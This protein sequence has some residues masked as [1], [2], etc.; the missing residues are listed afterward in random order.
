[1]VDR[2][3]T[4]VAAV[5]WLVASSSNVALLVV[6]FFWMYCVQVQ[7]CCWLIIVFS[8]NV[9]SVAI[10]FFLVESFSVAVFLVQAKEHLVGWLCC[11]TLKQCCLVF[12][13]GPVVTLLPCCDIIRFNAFVVVLC[14]VL[15]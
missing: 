9:A 10:L 15:L 8:C 2:C 4:A 5:F 3:I 12:V 1:M 6:L 14:C 13:S 11:V 7:Y